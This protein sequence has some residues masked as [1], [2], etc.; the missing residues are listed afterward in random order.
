MANKKKTGL[1]IIDMQNG[2]WAA[3]DKETRKNVIIQC[4]RAMKRGLPIFIVELRPKK[5]GHTSRYITRVV[6]KYNNVHFIE[7]HKDDG[8]KAVMDYLKTQNIEIKH[9]ITCGVNI[10][11]CLAETVRRLIWEY[12]KKVLI[13]MNACNCEFN[14]E[15]AFE[16]HYGNIDTEEVYTDSSVKLV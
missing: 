16:G 8:G 14:R 10:S 5:Y 1:L 9:F 13:V 6:E 2:F 3:K 11:F 4:E 15:D 12:K 7:K